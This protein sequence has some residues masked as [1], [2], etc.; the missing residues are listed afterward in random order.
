MGE[1]AQK[2][3]KLDR[4]ELIKELNIA[5]AEEWLAYYQYWIGAQ[6]MVGPMRKDVAEEFIEHGNEELKHAQWLSD[7]IIQLGGIPV[8]DPESWKKVA[9]CK[10]DAPT[11]AYVEKLIEQNVVAERCAIARYQKICDITHGKDFETFRLSAKI[12]KEEIEHEN[13]IESF[14]DDI[15]A[16]KLHF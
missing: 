14:G 6:V 13:E 12:L 9:Q 15:R 5:F 4:E 2:I 7:R 11:D 16:T 8:L 10:Y 3:I 1:M